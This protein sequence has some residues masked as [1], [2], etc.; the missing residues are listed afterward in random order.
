[1]VMAENKKVAGTIMVTNQQ[2]ETFFLVRKTEDDLSFLFEK[3]EE[4]T[5]FPMGIIMD[6]LL[7]HVTVDSESLRLMDLTNIKGEER[8]IPL[9]VFDLVERPDNEILLLNGS[10]SIIWRRAKDMADLLNECDSN[11]VP[12]YRS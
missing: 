12:I 6:S 11:V 3:I 7:S 9:F 8:T 1:M 4:G 5:K 10:E 2:G